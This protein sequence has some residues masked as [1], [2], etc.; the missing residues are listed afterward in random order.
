MVA[1]SRRRGLSIYANFHK[2]SSFVAAALPSK[3]FGPPTVARPTRRC[4]K[5]SIVQITLTT[6]S[7]REK[8]A[9]DVRMCSQIC[10]R[11]GLLKFRQAQSRGPVA[12]TNWKSRVWMLSVYRIIRSE[13]SGRIYPTAFWT[14]GDAHKLS[15]AYVNS[16]FLASHTRL[17]CKQHFLLVATTPTSPLVQWQ[18]PNIMSARTGTQQ[19]IRYINEDLGIYWAEEVEINVTGYSPPSDPQS[20]PPP[21]WTRIAAIHVDASSCHLDC[22]GLGAVRD[23]AIHR[24]RMFNMP[25]LRVIIIIRPPM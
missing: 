6:L 9:S 24:D 23:E 11:S 16:L 14:I 7:P 10:H 20:P 15:Q 17:I 12:K 5:S 4:R 8:I 22:D 18:G 25:Y 3:I 1:S 2:H 21:V 19:V 13:M